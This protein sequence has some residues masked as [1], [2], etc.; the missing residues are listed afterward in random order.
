MSSLFSTEGFFYKASTVI[1]N[2]LV[3]NLLWVLFSLPLVTIGASTTALF[4]VTGKI[5]RKENIQSILSAFWKSFKLNF[6]QA[7]IIWLI[8]IAIFFLLFINIQNIG[9]MGG[10]AR[11]IYPVQLVALLELFIINIYVFPLLSRH[12]ITVLGGLKAAFYIGNRHLLTT[13]MCLAVFPGLYYLLMI[14]GIFIL[15]IMGIYGFWISFLLNGKFEK[16]ILDDN[17]KGD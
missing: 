7:T 15:G 17:E 10:M 6:K 4:Y 2:L 11:Y 16:Y 8:I 5:V 3:L 14:H 9:L 13:I 1:Y 12:H